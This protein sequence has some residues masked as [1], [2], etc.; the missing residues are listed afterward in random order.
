MRVLANILGAL[1]LAG[2]VLAGPMVHHIEAV[3][4]RAGQRGTT[5]EVTLEGAHLKDPR[6][7]L[8]YRPGVRCTE[9]KALPSLPEPRSGIHGGF[10]QDM[11][12]CRFEIAADCPLGIHPFRLRTA[13]ELTMLSTFAVTPYTIVDEAEPGQ[14]RNDTLKTALDVKPGTSVRGNITNSQ[15]ADVDLYRVSATAGRHLSVEVNAVWLSERYYGG[16]EY[17]LMARILDAEGRELARNDDSAL[18]LQDPIVSTILPRDGDYFVEIKQPVFNGSATYLAH[19]GSHSRPLAVYPAG[20]P[21]GKKLSA[22]LLGDPAGDQTTQ[23]ALPDTDGDFDLFNDMPSPLPM[24]VSRYENVL[25]ERGAAETPVKTLPVALNGIIEQS[26]DDDSFRFSA[27]KGQRWRIRVFAR[28]LGSNLDPR[29]A[30]HRAG[31]DDIEIEGDDATLEERGFYAMS[32]QIQ[33]KEKM[34]PSIVWEPKEDGDF[35]LTMSDL[36]G[37]GDALSVYRIEIEP[38]R[39]EVSTFIAARVIDAVECPRLTSITVPQGNRWNVNI[40]LAEGQGNRCKGDLE[41]VATGL[42]EGVRMIAPRIVAGSKQAQA[43]FIATADV[44]PQVALITLQCRAVDG[45]PLVSRCQQ[46]FPFINRSGGHAW[47]TV[48]TDQYALAVTEAAPFSFDLVQP[49]I[50]LSQQSE[51]AVQ[52]K[53][54]RQ[55]GFNDA[56]EFQCDWLPPGVQSEPT[57]TIPAGQ[58]D[59]I[60]HLTADGNAKP[61]VWQLAVTA[62]TTGGSY[63]LGV[64][65]IRSATHFIDLTIAEPYVALKNHPAAV[66]RG[67]TA[68]IEWEVQHKKPFT[69]EAE[70]ILLGLPKGVSVVGTP[71]LKAGDAKLIFG[72]TATNEALMG[73]YKEL[74]CELVVKER[75]QEIR[76]RTGKGILRVDPAL[77]SVAAKP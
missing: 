48:V 14:G 52:V 21:A 75:G 67:A 5:L 56:L 8:F 36:R 57:V 59:A 51:L 63:Y 16:A 62:S 58:S 20:G 22:T 35:V 1:C 13:T 71:K 49:Q 64:G 72:I 7:I 3:T 38:V 46:S 65:R 77:N 45:T 42:P 76:Q 43:Q 18:H 40:N 32:A 29:I 61:G 39:D 4:P 23:I 66:R 31:S 73:Q 10:T 12:R 26:G 47:H 55:P 74:T 69:G 60:M 17:D 53:V 54:T 27:K 50:P 68:Q 9:I 41:L 33:R 44:K 30:I 70:A 2:P 6:E 34:D 24:R 28:T 11:V 37:L 25:E 19:I 15:L